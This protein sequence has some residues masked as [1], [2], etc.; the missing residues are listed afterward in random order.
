[1]VGRLKELIEDW[2]FLF[3]RGERWAAALTILRELAQLPYRHMR[4]VIV[5]RS[6]TDPL[7]DLQPR[8]ALE[9]R[10]FS[11]ADVELV[12]HVHRPSEARLCAR[13]L[14]RG[15]IG[16]VAFHRG[17]PAGYA[18]ASSQMDPNLERVNIELQPRDAFCVDAYTAPAFRGQGVQTALAIARLRRLRDLGFLSML[19]YIEEGNNPSLAVWQRKLGGQ[20]VGHMDFL[21][22]GP[23]RRVHYM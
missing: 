19:A 9:V 3:Q 20:V 1:M 11:W 8:I 7:P 5:N 12:R 6:L 17:Q 13:R 4:F 18:W 22:I 23:W 21:R 14:E 15:H 2:C 10:D 16:V